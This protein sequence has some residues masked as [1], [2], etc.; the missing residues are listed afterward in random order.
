MN[1]ERKTILKMLENGK[2]NAEEAEQLLKNIKNEKDDKNNVKYYSNS[3]SKQFKDISTIIGNKVDNITKNIEPTMKKVG[4]IIEEQTNNIFSAV[5]NAINNEKYKST[6][7]T[8]NIK[9]FEFS[10]YDK[11]NELSIIGLNGDINIKGYNGN[12]INMSIKYKGSNSE[13]EFIQ[14][15]NRYFMQYDEEKFNNISIDLIIPENLF[16]NIKVETSNGKINID[17]INTMFIDVININGKI[18]LNNISSVT[19]NTD[20]NN[21]ITIL[22]N[23]NSDKIN[24]QSCNGKVILNNIDSSELNV[25]NFNAQI[26]LNIYNLNKYNNYIWNLETNN[27]KIKFNMPRSNLLAYYIKAHTSLNKIEFNMLDFDF[28]DRNDNHIEAKSNNFSFAS[29]KIK[30]NAENSNSNIIFN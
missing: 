17:T 20:N 16:S 19:L 5:S 8:E 25:Q 7:K 21:N 6:A 11:N 1:E 12:K 26:E 10:V 4:K 13:I 22:S 2:I 9:K 28:L 30:I 3:N 27:E 15:G 18:E 29:K 23:V 24:I 14:A